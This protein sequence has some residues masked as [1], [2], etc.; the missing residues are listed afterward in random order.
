MRKRLGYLLGF[1]L[2]LLCMAE[3]PKL[4]PYISSDQIIK[5]IAKYQKEL[6]KKVGY[7]GSKIWN[8]LTDY[9][10]VKEDK[11][12]L[13]SLLSQLPIKPERRS[14][15]RKDLFRTL[16]KNPEFFLTTF[17]EFYGNNQNCLHWF[18]DVDRYSLKDLDF[19]EFNS[20]RVRSL[21]KSQPIKEEDRK[22]CIKTRNQRIGLAH[23]AQK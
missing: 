4:E 12:L 20:S 22:F 19:S 3:S 18:F 14:E 21:S 5:D 15:Y 13:N 9:A 8:T 23:R 6:P 1:S 7:K 10:A 2:S 11:K 16:K 17:D